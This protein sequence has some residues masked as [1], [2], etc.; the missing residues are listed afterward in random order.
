[1]HFA[2]VNRSIHWR[3]R[4]E[5]IEMKKWRRARAKESDEF[6]FFSRARFRQ[7]LDFEAPASPARRRLYH[8]FIRAA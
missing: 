8:N 6:L 2:C 3:A 1:M 4:S 5:K 7:L